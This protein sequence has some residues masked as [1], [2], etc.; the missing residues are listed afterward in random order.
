M[1]RRVEKSLSTSGKGLMT[2]IIY[3]ASDYLPRRGRTQE[4]DALAVYF[5]M[6]ISR[7]LGDIHLSGKKVYTLFIAPA[8]AMPLS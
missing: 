4:G 2:H 6:N 5:A 1:C 8:G 3:F 7:V